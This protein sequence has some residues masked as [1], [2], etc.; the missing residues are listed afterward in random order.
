MCAAK[1]I[2]FCVILSIGGFNL[3][4]ALPTK[5]NTTNENKELEYVNKEQEQKCKQTAN[6]VIWFSCYSNR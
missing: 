3:S 1:S 4:N 2:L 5:S 6:A